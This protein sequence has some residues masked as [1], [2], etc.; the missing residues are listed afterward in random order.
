MQAETPNII[1]L[2]IDTLRPD[3]VGC[4]GSERPLTPN[5]DRLA[6][7]G[8]RFTTA[9]TG[10]SWTQAAFPTI[11]TSSYASMYG[12][13]LGPLAAARP[14]PIAA[15]AGHGYTTAGFSTSPLLSQAYGYDRSFQHFVDLEPFVKD[16][17]LRS[18]KGG[19]WLLRQPAVHMIAQRLGRRLRPAALYAP[20]DRVTDAVCDWLQSA[21][22]PFFIWAHYM[23]VHWPYHLEENLT[24]PAAVAQAWRDLEHLYRA[25]WH[26]ATITA[27]QR[28]RYIE[29]YEQAVSYTD[30]QIGHLL[31]CLEERGLAGN[32]IVVIVSDHG[33]EFLEHGRWGH[34][35][36]NLYDEILKV[37]LI[38]GLPG[39]TGERVIRRQVR[40][41]DLMPTLLELANCPPPEG[42]EGSSLV[43]LWAAE[44]EPVAPAVSISEMWRDAWQII[45]VRNDE[46]KYI[47]DS[48]TSEQ[49][50]LFNLQADPAE[51]RNVAQIERNVVDEFH[52]HMF[53]QRQRAQATKPAVNDGKL[54]LDEDLLTR[55]RG[56]GYVK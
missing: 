36:N 15:L 37:P 4:Y 14:D 43:P 8:L 12:G 11:L 52:R 28:T 42:L 46:W 24:T 31:Q 7:Q 10:G 6:A 27:A 40:T 44:D 54:E 51:T 16:P 33:E 53:R 45:A 56:L 23:D 34:W 21:G 30:A 13:C 35:E 20:A 32:S 2:T 48:Q 29:L 3:R 39:Q 1:L 50:M 25:N 9:I 41:L 47:W 55:L 26:G 38:I 19:Q 49:P 22:S 18:L 17:V 5:I